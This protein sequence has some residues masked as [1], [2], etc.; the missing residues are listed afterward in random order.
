MEWQEKRSFRGFPWCI[1]ISKWTESITIIL[2]ENIEKA[3]LY[4]AYASFGGIGNR[5]PYHAH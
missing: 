5:T 1:Y 3:G 4:T 2:N